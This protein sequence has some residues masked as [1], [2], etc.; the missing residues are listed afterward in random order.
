MCNSYISV[1]DRVR[2]KYF[3]HP[4]RVYFKLIKFCMIWN[5][6]IFTKI[7]MLNFFIT[8]CIQTFT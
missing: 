4:V 1:G 5:Q 6:A 8:S 2:G 7:T 3:D